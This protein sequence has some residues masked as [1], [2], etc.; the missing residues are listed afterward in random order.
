MYN[1]KVVEVR[2]NHLGCPVGRFRC[3]GENVID[4]M[5]VLQVKKI[6]SSLFDRFVE[7]IDDSPW[8][9]SSDFVDIVEE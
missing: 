8:L 3:V 6:P 7:L 1:G 4:G 2:K 5:V 9:V